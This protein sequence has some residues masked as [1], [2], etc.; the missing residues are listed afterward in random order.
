[1]LV[2]VAATAFL[3]ALVVAD[4]LHTVFESLVRLLAAG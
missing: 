2:A 4:P 3:A 1:V